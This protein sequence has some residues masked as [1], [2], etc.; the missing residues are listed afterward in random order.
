MCVEGSR[1]E[2]PW[3][4]SSICGLEYMIPV[5]WR[6][7]NEALNWKFSEH[8]FFFCLRATLKLKSLLPA[9]DETPLNS[10]PEAILRR[11]LPSRPPQCRGSFSTQTYP[12]KLEL[13]SKE[14]NHFGVISGLFRQIG[15]HNS[16]FVLFCFFWRLITIK[17][18]ESVKVFPFSF[19]KI[20]TKFF[21][22]T[23]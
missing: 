6:S 10:N 19:W 13:V 18:I 7:R 8:C 3:Y 4:Y 21:F 15:G 20:I 2:D 5:R 16:R 1:K 14:L 17:I 23:S 11:P 12:N 22:F 9:G